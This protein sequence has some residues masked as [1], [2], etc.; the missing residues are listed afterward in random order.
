[1]DERDEEET[2]VRKPYCVP[3]LEEHAEFE[4]LALSCGKIAGQ[5][6]P[7][8]DGTYGDPSAS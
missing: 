7:S 1:M 6:V 5:P 8:C 2:P 4:T 3:A